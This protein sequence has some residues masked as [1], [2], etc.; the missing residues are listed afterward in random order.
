[1]IDAA[2]NRLRAPVFPLNARTLALTS[3]GLGFLRPAPGTWG[4][5]PPVVIAF[6]LMILGVGVTGL[7]V[8]LGVILAASCV[9]CVS[10]GG[11]A[12]ERFGRKDAGEVVIDET[13]GQCV[14]ILFLSPGAVQARW[15]D[16]GW[17]GL[18]L[19]AASVC[20]VAFLLFRLFDIVKPWP[21]R[22]LESLPAGWGVL[23]DD[24]MAGFYALIAVHLLVRLVT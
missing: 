22:Q 13:A 6:V 8:V 12:E 15:F 11:Y 3:L 5:V 14:A 24:L 9:V 4:S 21:A 10:L 7:N 18:F 1:M 23:A 20:A 16:A 2:K 17:F 19:A